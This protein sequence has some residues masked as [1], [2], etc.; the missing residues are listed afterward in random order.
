[1][2]N[3]ILIFLIG[4]FCYACNTP[5]GVGVK[6][7]SSTIMAVHAVDQSVQTDFA[8]D[9]SDLLVPDTPVQPVNWLDG[10]FL[11]TVSSVLGLIYE[12]LARKIPTSKTLSLFGVLYKLLNYFIPDKSKNGGT[13]QIRDKL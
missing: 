7:P 13:L 12:F 11:L 3:L 6:Q 5:N 10:D 8:V 2:K 1:M 4:L 9:E